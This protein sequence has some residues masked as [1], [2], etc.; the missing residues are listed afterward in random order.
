MV[1]VVFILGTNIFLFALNQNTSFQEGI[2]EVNQNDIDCTDEKA[3]A[4]NTTYSVTDNTV[5]VGT[6]VNND[7]PISIQIL[8]LWTMDTTTQ[9]Y[10]YADRLNI[11]L[12]S[13]DSL[14]LTG[15]SA[16]PVFLSGSSPS[17]VFTS[18]LVT[19]RGNRI[20]LELPVESEGVIVA[21][22]SQG[23]GSMTLD[24]TQFRYF[25]FTSEVL[26]NYP[27]GTRG[28]N[29]PQNSYCAFGCYLTNL[30]P[31]MLPIVIDSHSLLWQP[32]RPGVAEGAWFIVNVSVNGSIAGTYSNITVGYGETKM[33]V[34]GSQNDLSLGAFSKG[35]TPNVVTTVATFLLLHGTIGSAAYA[36]NIPFVSLF[37][38]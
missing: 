22:L 7:G 9:K 4:F 10:G 35:K 17:D 36:Q 38:T 24:L 26:N 3:S 28:F 23:I 14:N 33:F 27:S 2:S 1:L 15:S 32:G 11:S 6:H 18:W 20:Q 5:W 21:Q 31:S 16:V 8:T 29:V 25:T 30:D 19:D 12:K 34:F 37:Y 13:G